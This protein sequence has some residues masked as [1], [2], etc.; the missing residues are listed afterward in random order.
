MTFD[1]SMIFFNKCDICDKR[2]KKD[3]GSHEAQ[4]AVVLQQGH[5]SE[6]S[7][8]ITLKILESFQKK[9]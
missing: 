4:R 1:W 3:F 8:V 6:A 5:V 9:V 7:A 2:K